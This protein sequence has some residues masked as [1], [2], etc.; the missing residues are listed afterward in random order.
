MTQNKPKSPRAAADPKVR[1]VVVHFGEVDRTR[2]CLESLSQLDWP[3]ECLEIVVVDNDES[4]PISAAISGDF[5]NVRTIVAKRNLGFG[6]GCN[7]ALQDLQGVDFVALLNN[8]AIAEPTWLRELVSA[9]QSDPK[10]GAATSKM[11]FT[12]KYREVVVRFEPDSASRLSWRHPAIAIEDVRDEHVSL[13]DKTHISTKGL[14]A[15]T[16]NLP[17]VYSNT[18]GFRLLVPASATTIRMHLVCGMSGVLTMQSADASDQQRVDA[19]PLWISTTVAGEPFDLIANAGNELTD[20]GNATDRGWLRRNGDDPLLE[21]KGLVFAWC[22]GAA[23]LRAECL[24]DT[25]LFD[26]SLF[27]YY[28]D[29]ELS[30][31][32]NSL[33]WHTVYVPSAI[34]RHEHAANTQEGSP[35]KSVNTL[36]NRLVVLARHDSPKRTVRVVL[37]HATT[38]GAYAARDGVRAV[39]RGT[40]MQSSNASNRA[41]AFA[42]FVR[43][44]P[45]T[46]RARKADK[47]AIARRRDF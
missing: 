47:A 4:R 21:S 33:G 27:L 11:L 36:R 34:V 45:H 18:P 31:R 17:H 19:G 16:S 44:L 42:G 9:L 28:E 25:G 39:V 13:L 12:D 7:L 37:R 6:G 38:I 15:R 32:A 29:L 5:P 40:P 14:L 43:L 10:A 2:R 24:H 41:R 3:K 23:V 35:L 8:D 30:W 1:A 46:L 26:E 22:G 20:N